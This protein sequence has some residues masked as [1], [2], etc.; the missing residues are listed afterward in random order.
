MTINLDNLLEQHN[1]LVKEQYQAS[2]NGFTEWFYD[3][4]DLTT[5]QI[6]ISGF[7][8][9]SGN[10]V[11]LDFE[12]DTEVSQDEF[13]DLAKQY[14]TDIEKYETEGLDVPESIEKFK[15]TFG[16]SRWEEITNA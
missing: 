6:E 4:A 15:S 2:L 16:A 3:K 5:G 11:I 1:N 12:A 13:D 9:I 7:E 10:P 14:F 8:T